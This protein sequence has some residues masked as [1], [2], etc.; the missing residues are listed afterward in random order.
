MMYFVSPAY[1]SVFSNLYALY[2]FY[3]IAEGAPSIENGNYANA[4]PTADG[5]HWDGVTIY[6]A[7]PVIMSYGNQ[8]TF[9]NFNVYSQERPRGGAAMGADTCFYFTALHDDQTGGVL[10]CAVARS[11]QE[12]LL[13][14]GG[15][16]A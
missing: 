6:A 15:R 16:R 10:R 7:N 8:N 13:R 3:G 4:Q 11:L 14:A 9:S 5:A 12:S 1:A 2:L